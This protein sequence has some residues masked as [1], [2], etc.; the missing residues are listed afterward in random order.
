MRYFVLALLLGFLKPAPAA[1]DDVTSLRFL[2][3]TWE[4]VNT[5][6][7][8]TG[9]F[10]FALG[11]QD[12][13]ITRTNYAIYAARD[14]H[15]ASRHDDLMV[16]Y[17]EGDQLRADYFDSEQHVIRYV[18]QSPADRQVIF[19]SEPTT[20]E[21][22]YRLTYIARADGTLDGRFEIAAAGSSEFK[23]YLRWS[24]RRVK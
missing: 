20:A 19:T 13:L 8:D 11:V 5:T 17:R 16:I 3:G 2:I 4:A 9:G 6:P 14:G 22:R 12:H 24:A 10:T 21:P 18:V 1:A 15:P 23:D 7:R